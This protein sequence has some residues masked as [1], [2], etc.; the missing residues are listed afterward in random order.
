MKLL[1]IFLQRCEF[2]QPYKDIVV[3]PYADK[4]L[5]IEAEYSDKILQFE[6]NYK[7]KDVY[8]GV[9]P[10][11]KYKNIEFNEIPSSY[12]MWAYTTLDLSGNLVKLLAT[13]IINNCEKFNIDSDN[14]IVNIN[15]EKQ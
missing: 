3:K 15:N 5:K 6:N 13:Y 1:K 9:M 14:L 10:F 7:N 11:G 4:I 12:I 2:Q 8:Y